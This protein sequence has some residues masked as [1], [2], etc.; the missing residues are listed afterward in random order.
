M[1]FPFKIDTLH[2]KKKSFSSLGLVIIMS[3]YMF[4]MH[5]PVIIMQCES[6]QSIYSNFTIFMIDLLHIKMCGI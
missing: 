4:Y 1:R 5:V 3:M 2:G 6:P